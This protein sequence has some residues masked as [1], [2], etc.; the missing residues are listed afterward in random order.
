[1]P[2]HLKVEMNGQEISD[3]FALSVSP[4]IV[5]AKWRS[6]GRWHTLAATHRMS[7][8]AMPHVQRHAGE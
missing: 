3:F 6:H 7:V 4:K 1:M 8:T 5:F 2:A